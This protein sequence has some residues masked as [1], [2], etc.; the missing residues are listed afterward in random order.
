MVTPIFYYSTY[1]SL[2]NV[3]KKMIQMARMY[4]FSPYQ[5]LKYI[6]INSGRKAFLGAI[7]T[8]IGFA[9]KSGITAEVLVLPKV[10]FGMMLYNSKIYFDGLNLASYTILL[11]ILAIL[12]E[13]LIIFAAKKVTNP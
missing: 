6:Y 2:Q 12:V 13:K 1:Q 8:G 9:F 10:S 7:E 3:D 4:D 5:K 11:I